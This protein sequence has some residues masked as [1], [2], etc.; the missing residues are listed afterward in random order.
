MYC[1]ALKLHIP[2]FPVVYIPATC[3]WW[4]I[5]SFSSFLWQK[6]HTIVERKSLSI[7]GEFS[8]G[9][10]SKRYS[11][12]LS[13]N[14]VRYPMKGRRSSSLSCGAWNIFNW[15]SMAGIR[16]T[17]RQDNMI[18][19]CLFLSS[20]ADS[21]SAYTTTGAGISNRWSVNRNRVS[22]FDKSY[23]S[24][25]S[26]SSRCTCASWSWTAL[27]DPKVRSEEVVTE[28]TLHVS[29]CMSILC[30]TLTKDSMF[31]IIQV[32]EHIHQSTK[33]GYHPNADVLHRSTVVGGGIVNDHC[34]KQNTVLIGNLKIGG[35]DQ[36]WIHL[37]HLAISS[38]LNHIRSVER[39]R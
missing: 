27:W 13:C 39:S 15:L 12:T 38:D 4:R 20:M 36:R 5:L 18:G 29:C 31:E 24:L 25:S 2:P 6:G 23:W 9:N 10:S 14:Y 1:P 21:K 35:S 32:L 37:N 3:A 28:H 11:F 30:I 19:L 33:S 17:A 34:D 16:D 8:R 26:T 7:L 22:S